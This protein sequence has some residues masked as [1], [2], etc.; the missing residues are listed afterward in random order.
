MNFH[1]NEEQRMLK[2]SARGF[3]SDRCT[4]DWVREMEADDLGYSKKLW[5]DMAELGW[6]GLMLPE[7]HQGFGWSLLDLM[8][9]VEEMGRTCLP[10]P[11]LPT[12]LG[13]LT[14]EQ[15]GSQELKADILPKVAAGELVLTLAFLEA[16]CPAYAPSMVTTTAQEQKQGYLLEGNKLFVAD[17]HAADYLIVSARTGG[18]SD[19]AR[20]ISLFLLPLQSAGLSLTRLKTI[21]GDKQFE[22]ALDKVAAPAQSLLGPAGNGWPVLDRILKMGALAKC[23]EM[24][25]GGSKVL[26]MTVEY[27]KERVQFGLPI[28]QY[29]AVQHHCANMLMDLEGSRFITYKAAWAMA[30]GQPSEL[31]V[32]SAKAFVS[33]AYNR[34]VGLGHQIGAGTAY[35]AEHDMTLY[36]RRAKAAELAFG[37]AAFHREQAA[38]VLGL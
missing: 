32:A 6:L 37:D 23:A 33:E 14:V 16:G 29:Q 8:V 19:S 10:G 9:L 36:S 27:A 12:T 7:E 13:A 3:L 26:E 28:G 20:G 30:Q 22:V 15:A 25:G 1:L 31:L 5:S 18:E 11:F 24:V 38:Q 34:V 2:E 21:A 4:S 17:A 35:M